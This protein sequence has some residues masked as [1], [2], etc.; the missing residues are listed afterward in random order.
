MKRIIFQ[1]VFFT[2]ILNVHGVDL[3]F[4]FEQINNNNG[5]PSN[6]IRRVKH[7][8]SCGPPEDEGAVFGLKWKK[9]T[10]IGLRQM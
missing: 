10:K 8:T 6:E 9:G 5:L 1:I 2:I 4:N 3:K 7:L